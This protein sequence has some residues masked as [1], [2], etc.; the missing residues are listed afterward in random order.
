MQKNKVFIVLVSIM[1]LFSISSLYAQSIEIV[2]HLLDAK[3]AEYG[4]TAYMVAV[5]SGIADESIT[6]TE[7]VSI[8]SDKQYGF[9]QKKA[10]D[11]VDFGE[12]SYMIMQ[13][14]ELDGG[15]MYKLIPS[16]RYAFR[17]LIYLGI[18]A[19]ET[20]PDSIITG[21]DVINILSGAMAAKES[22]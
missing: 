1:I 4:P 3:T 15:L 19:Q 16:R 13:A 5:G 6:I 17:E 22:E 10:E 14:L 21:A 2:D 18:I 7:A 8:L 20:Q 9:P 12:I 11:P